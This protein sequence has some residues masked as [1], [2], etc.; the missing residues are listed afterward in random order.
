[1]NDINKLLLIVIVA[2]ACPLCLPLLE[3]MRGEEECKTKKC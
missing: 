2:L 3:D 1:M